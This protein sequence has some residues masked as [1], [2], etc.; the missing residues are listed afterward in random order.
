MRRAVAVVAIV[1]VC[2]HS[3]FSE[4]RLPAVIG[5]DLVLQRDRPVPIWGWAD[6]G[7]QVALVLRN[8]AEVVEQVHTRADQDGNWQ[9]ELA[10]RPA[11]GPYSL[12]VNELELTGV[13]YGEVW[14]CSGQ[15]NMEWP[16]LAAD[17]AEMEI[18]AA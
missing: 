12:T 18:A 2:V 13:M 15:S 10:P 16:V 6:A 3:G 8:S 1:L 7:E 4:V 9:A 17:A 14:L 5:S 11:G